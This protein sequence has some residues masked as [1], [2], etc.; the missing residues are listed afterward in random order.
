MVTNN[1]CRF[2]RALRRGRC[3]AGAQ[4]RAP[5][6]C[7]NTVGTTI[8][9]CVAD[10]PRISCATNLI[11]STLLIAFDVIC[12]ISYGANAFLTRFDAME[13]LVRHKFRI[14]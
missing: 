13:E 5:W 2:H 11:V 3:S 14:E 8:S 9:S 1:I 10:R 12:I 7:A 4:R 6:L